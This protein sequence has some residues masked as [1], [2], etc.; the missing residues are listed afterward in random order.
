MNPHWLAQV[1]LAFFIMLNLAACD[2]NKPLPRSFPEFSLEEVGQ[3]PVFQSYAQPICVAL[4]DAGYIMPYGPPFSWYDFSILQSQLVLKESTKTLVTV[5]S[6]HPTLQ[7][8]VNWS[9][10]GDFEALPNA[11]SQQTVD[12]LAEEA[13]NICSIV[14][15]EAQKNGIGPIDVHIYMRDLF[16]GFQVEYGAG[17]P[18]VATSDCEALTGVYVGKSIGLNPEG[19]TPGQCPSLYVPN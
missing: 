16:V 9:I 6:D 7:V 17:A 12:E 19:Q 11:V 2:S 8:V 18:L 15:W 14:Q 13:K 4:E 10:P 5:P 1:T 3:Q